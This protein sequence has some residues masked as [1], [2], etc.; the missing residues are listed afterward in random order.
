[1]QLLL[2]L[3]KFSSVYQKA[4]CF[5]LTLTGTVTLKLKITDLCREAVEAHFHEQS[6][7]L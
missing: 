5:M 4:V 1:M 2:T 7:F 3:S 6:S